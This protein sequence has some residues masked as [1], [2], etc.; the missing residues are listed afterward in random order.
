VKIYT[1]STASGPPSP[2]GE[3][4]TQR[5]DNPSEFCGAESE[6]IHLIH[7]KRSPFSFSG[8]AT[9]F[10]L[11]TFPPT[12]EFPAG[13]GYTQRKDNPSEFCGAKPTSLCAREAKGGGISP[14][15]RERG[16]A[17]R[18]EKYAVLLI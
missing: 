16:R 12:G 6:N 17:T 15:G 13:E 18:I 3:G 2:T 11:R 14:V 10:V 7:R 9:P 5:K 1:S 4:Y 8:D